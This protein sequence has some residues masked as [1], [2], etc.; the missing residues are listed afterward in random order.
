MSVSDEVGVAPLVD[1]DADVVA[2]PGSSSP[3]PRPSRD[4]GLGERADDDAGRRRAVAVDEAADGRVDQRDLR[5]AVGGM[6]AVRRGRC[7]RSTCKLESVMW[8]WV[9]APFIDDAARVDLEGD[10]VEVEPAVAGEVKAPRPTEPLTPS[11]PPSAAPPKLPP[12]TVRRA[13]PVSARVGAVPC[14]TGA[15]LVGVVGDAARRHGRVDRP[16]Q[17]RSRREAAGAAP[18]GDPD[19][20]ERHVAAGRPD[21]AESPKL[22]SAAA[23]TP[24][25]AWR[26]PAA[27]GWPTP[28]MPGVSARS[29]SPA[30]IGI[31]AGCVAAVVDAVV[32]Q[33][34]RFAPAPA[35]AALAIDRHGV[36]CAQVVLP[37]ST[38]VGLA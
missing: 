30:G 32:S 20:V 17:R 37:A 23:T 11:A 3:S 18:S 7:W 14:P 6:D 31:G 16:A 34:V 1:E 24:D 5:R 12:L 35:A 21:R 26:C 4:P 15:Q 38:P 28:A 9:A 10:V 8:S 19:A 25:H 36:A 33:T 29:V 2:A 13:L 27:R 22:L